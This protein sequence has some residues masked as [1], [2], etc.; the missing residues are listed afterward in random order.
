MLTA[1]VSNGTGK[2]MAYD[3]LIAGV[4]VGASF[5]AGLGTVKAFLAIVVSALMVVLLGFRI[6]NEYR[7]A[8]RQDLKDKHYEDSDDES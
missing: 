6:Y 3:A 4:G 5:F 7:R 8:K 2:K 1:I